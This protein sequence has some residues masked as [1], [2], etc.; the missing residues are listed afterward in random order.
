[1]GV[2]LILSRYVCHANHPLHDDAADC[3]PDLNVPIPVNEIFTWDGT[4][5]LGNVKTI[6]ND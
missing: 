2:L 3:I 1:V 5:W 4:L 6:M